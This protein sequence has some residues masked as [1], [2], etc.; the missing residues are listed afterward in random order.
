MRI[1]SVLNLALMAAGLAT[2]APLP[3]LFEQ[4]GAGAY[5]V[6]GSGYAVAVSG[7]GMALAT[8][9]GTAKLTWMGANGGRLQPMEPSATRVNYLTGKDPRKW[10]IGLATFGRVRMAELYRGIDVV[11]YGTERQLEYDFVVKAGADAGTIRFALA[12]KLGANG[13]LT[14]ANGLR[15]RKPVARQDGREIAARFEQ[16]GEGVFGIRVGSYDRGREL[17][18]DPVLTYGTYLGGTLADDARGVAADA[19]GNAYVVG[20]TRSP[21]FPGTTRGQTFGGQDVYVAKL[22]PSGRAL[23]WVTYI[24]GTGTDTGMGIAL[25]AA[26]A[27][28]VTG[29]TASTNFPVTANAPQPVLAGGSAVTDAFVLKLAANGA[30]LVYSTFLGGSQSDFG[31]AIQVDRNGAAYVGGRTDSTDFPSTA[32]DTLPARGAGDGFVTKVAADGASFVYSV[33]LGGFALDGVNAIAVDA[34]G[35][36]YVT[37]ET[38]SENFPVTEGAY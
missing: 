20:S 2:A 4:Q 34:T 19:A 18:I 15:W 8:A 24:G 21:D 36:V 12:A 14:L 9:A 11:Y 33:L 28:Y 13:E 35:A 32:R 30:A 7:D 22:N 38:R 1:Q 3:V 37:G 10:R 26:G 6:R 23:D 31:N 17:V 29:F 5:R 27:I 16:R 25:D